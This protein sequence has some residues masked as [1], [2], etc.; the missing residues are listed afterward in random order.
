MISGLGYA[1]FGSDKLE[2][3]RQFGTNLVGFQAIERGNSLL[4]FRMDDRKQ[5]IVIDRA[6]GDGAR[7]F[8]WEVADGTAL[9]ALAARLEAAGVAVDRR[10][11]DAGGCAARARADLVSP[12]RPATGWR[13]SM[14]PRVD[15][16]AVRPGRSI[17]GFRTGPLGLGHVVLT[18][19]NIEPIMRVL[20]GRA[21][22]RPVRLHRKPFRAYFFHVNPRHHALALIETGQQRHASP[23]G[24]TVLARRC[25]P[26]LRHRARPSRA[27]QR[28]AR[29]PHQRSHDVVLCP[30]RRRPSWSNTAGAAARS[31]R[32]PGSRSRCTTVRACGAMTA[33]W[34]PANEPRGRARDAVEAARRRPARAGAGDRGQLQADV[35]HLR[36]VGRGAKQ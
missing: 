21:R 9:D 18:V 35:R 10:A 15:G 23:D 3:W 33:I 6:M 26:V 34:L 11:A 16:R 27:R 2:D 8:G 36:V 24:G 30:A 31:I 29:P 32:R 12:T 25:R 13:P 28:H 19:E 5:R 1:G 17:S 14:A 4:S 20:S 22:L 7:F